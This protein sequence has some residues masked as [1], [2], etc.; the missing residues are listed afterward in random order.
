M[1]IVQ[2]KAYNFFFYELNRRLIKEKPRKG[3]KCFTNAS[4]KCV[5]CVCTGRDGDSVGS[6]DRRTVTVTS[7]GRLDTLPSLYSSPAARPLHPHS[8]NACYFWAVSLRSRCARNYGAYGA[9]HTYGR[10]L[11]DRNPTAAIRVRA[12]S[13]T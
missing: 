7:G 12:C 3:S 6:K 13:K 4:R 11:Y 5:V 9:A 1:P 2:N 10:G 8:K